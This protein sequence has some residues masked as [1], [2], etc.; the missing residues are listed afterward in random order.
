MKRLFSIALIGCLLASCGGDDVT[1]TS[2]DTTITNWLDAAGL[3]ATRDD[4]TG[5]YYF[6]DTLNPSGAAISGGDVVAI[7]YTLN[8]LQGNLIASYQAGNGDSLIF[9]VGASAVYP[10]GLDFGVKQMRVGE[11]FHFI[12]PPAQAYPDILSGA[13]DPRGIYELIVEAVGVF[14]ENDL[15]LQDLVDIDDYITT[16]NLNDTVANPLDRVEQFL[17]SGISFKRLAAGDGPVPLNGD[18]IRVDYTGRFLDDASFG[19]DAG[20]EWTYGSGEPRELLPAFEFGVSLMQ[21]GERAL[22]MVP[23][24]QGYRE[25]ALVVPA[26][27]TAELVEEAVI[28]D[29]VAR[30]PPYRSLLFEITRVN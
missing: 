7:Y 26:S 2:T 11:R 1:R 8:D 22:V 19:S 4:G 29:Y 6:A 27:I 13:L 23:S 5:I 10:I 21:R 25:S 28:P 15:F 18:T 9:K 16:N 17:A 20:F 12:L 3:T 24:S 30:I 14:D